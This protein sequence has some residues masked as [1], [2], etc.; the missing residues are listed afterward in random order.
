MSTKKGK[1]SKKGEKGSQQIS[2]STAIKQDA[3]DSLT[4]EY[5]ETK[6]R[7]MTE[8]IVRMKQ[9]CEDL[10]K[11]NEALSNAQTK[12]NHDKQDIVEFLNIKVRDHEKMISGLE[13][14]AHHLEEEKHDIAIRSKNEVDH[15]RTSMQLEL[16]NMQTQCT[17][18]K[19]EL[20]ELTAFS[21]KKK[22][23]ELQIVQC[24]DLL[25]NKRIEY[26]DT[27]HNIE[28]KVLQDKNQMKREMLQK[29]N[30]AV[31]NF[32]RVADQQMAETTKRAIREN[33]AIT[34]QLKKMSCKTIE[35]IGENDELKVKITKLK[36]SNSL[37]TGSEQELVKR[38]QA[39]Q[40]VIKML[41]EKLKESDQMLDLA[42]ESEQLGEASGACE[43]KMPLGFNLDTSEVLTKE[44]KKEIEAL[45][46]DYNVLVSRLAEVAD[47]TNEIELAFEESLGDLPSTN[48][49]PLLKPDNA[50]QLQNNLIM[51]IN[52]L[53]MLTWFESSETDLQ[54]QN[55]AQNIILSETPPEYDITVNLESQNK[56]EISQLVVYNRSNSINNAE[57][58][59]EPSC[60]IYNSHDDQSGSAFSDFSEI[61]E[62]KARPDA[63]KA[64]QR[65]LSPV[66][67]QLGDVSS[68]RES[69]SLNPNVQLTPILTDIPYERNRSSGWHTPDRGST[70]LA[71][72]QRR[73]EPHHI[74][75][76]SNIPLKHQT[77]ASIPR[78]QSKQDVGVQTNPLPFGQSSTSQYLLGELRPWGPHAVCF[79][80]KG[81]GL[82]QSRPARQPEHRM[83][84]IPRK[85]TPL[86]SH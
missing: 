81:A 24:K 58:D 57:L 37:L 40:R 9:K 10:T 43:E 7:D 74:H 11:E 71:G 46:Y 64:P 35:L 59:G 50:S 68:K 30:E 33:M 27:I 51:M 47:V 62:N 1:K 61:N 77:V 79:P 60:N 65:T 83:I 48:H 36:I 53:K 84:P 6:V 28:R 82:Y 41:V 2:G 4:L 69:L 16:E 38:S 72:N 22:E 23:M 54:M 52:R 25:E 34:S 45:Q 73:V 31:A 44:M 15:I 67:Y 19:S 3:M 39:N 49:P 26:R 85:K 8:K 63:M 86:V 18:F 70:C 32:R 13:L 75:P 17:K 5:F 42:F 66:S 12:F 21:A 55:P 76:I 80:K 29:V 20:S 56:G 14:K 78:E